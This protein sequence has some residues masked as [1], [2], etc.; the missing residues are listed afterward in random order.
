VFLLT[1]CQTLKELA[2]LR[3]V[4]FAID[5][6]ADVQLAGIDVDRIRS[7]SDLGPA[8]ALKLTRAVAQ[9][10]LPLSFQLHLLAENPPDNSVSAR[11]VKLDWM[12][13]LEDKETISGVFED[14]VVLPPGQPQDV[15]FA[16]SLDLMEF[17]EQSAP[18]LVDLALAISGQGGSPKEI[19]LRATP[20]VNTSLGPIRY[21]QPITII[22]RQVGSG[23][24]P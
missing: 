4:N 16:I 12:L 2:A 1:G 11:L 3:Q 18:D 19:K 14:E 15:P 24:T 5:R 21:P 8:D 6:V 23:S 7:F 13:L 22:S 17:F 20:T 10:E 9:R